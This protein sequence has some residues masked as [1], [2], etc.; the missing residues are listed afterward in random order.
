MILGLVCVGMVLFIRCAII[1]VSY[2]APA[3]ITTV[4]FFVEI[5]YFIIVPVFSLAATTFGT[6]GL[7]RSH[8]NI[9][10]YRTR[11]TIFSIVGCVGAVSFIIYGIVILFE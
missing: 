11:S 4:G 2:L 1:Y 3:T 9:D 5:L 6:I 7:I 8:D 10:R